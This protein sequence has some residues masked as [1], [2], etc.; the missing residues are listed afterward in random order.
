MTDWT[1]LIGAY[2]AT[3]RP[4]TDGVLLE[5]RGPWTPRA[6]GTGTADPPPDD[7]PDWRRVGGGGVGWLAPAGARRLVVVAQPGGA[8]SGMAV[9]GRPAAAAEQQAAVLRR[10][11]RAG[12][13]LRA[14]AVAAA[15]LALLAA[16]SSVV[17]ALYKC[18]PGRIADL[19]TADADVPPP[20]YTVDPFL[21][22]Y[23][24]PT[25]PTTTSTSPGL[26][27]NGAAATLAAGWATYRC[28]RPLTSSLNAVA[29]NGE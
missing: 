21:D 27:I 4:V 28:Q 2:R 1:W 29:R 17:W 5:D 19:P 6:S 9:P 13:G 7:V 16:A 22:T 14:V 10:R 20:V 8:G 23:R 25:P 26:L 24:P 15:I 11:S 3:S 12:D 18:K